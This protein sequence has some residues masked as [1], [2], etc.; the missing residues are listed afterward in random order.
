MA[1]SE[2]SIPSVHL[3]AWKKFAAAD[4]F[5]WNFIKVFLPEG[6]GGSLVV[7]ALRY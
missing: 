6:P 2:Y 4:V 1:K 3:F 5:A 7:K